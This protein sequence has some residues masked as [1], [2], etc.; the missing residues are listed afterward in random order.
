ML[1]EQLFVDAGAEIEAFEKR[2]DELARK[3]ELWH[4]WKDNLETL[5]KHV[6]VTVGGSVYEGIAETVNN[7]GSLLLRLSD[8]TLKEI[9]AGDVTLRA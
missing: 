7:A 4:E 1:F 8:G 2:Y 3:T 5:G 6:K 9:P